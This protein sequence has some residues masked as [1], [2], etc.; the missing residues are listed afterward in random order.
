MCFFEVCRSGYNRW[1]RNSV[2]CCNSCSTLSRKVIQIVKYWHIRWSG[3][4]ICNL[5]IQAKVLLRWFQFCGFHNKPSLKGM[6]IVLNFQ[7][8][9][10]YKTSFCYSQILAIYYSEVSILILADSVHV[11]LH[12]PQLSSISHKWEY[13]ML[14]YQR[15]CLKGSIVFSFIIF[16][17]LSVA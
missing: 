14:S 9:K 15:A 8:P 1:I 13:R 10:L 16:A 12:S 2:L 17:I 3:I 4:N 6:Q 5:S 7:L 11:A